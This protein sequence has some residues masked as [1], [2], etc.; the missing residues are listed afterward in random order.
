MRVLI[1]VGGVAVALVVGVFL[2]DRIMLW[3]EA[4]GWVYWRMTQP[5]RS[6]AGSA[7]LELQSMLEP[8]RKYVLEARR[9]EEES[10]EQR[11]AQGDG[12]RPPKI[13]DV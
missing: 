1:V 4:R 8:D 11:D 10:V 13:P 6:G 5:N 3:M 12:N 7:F 9:Q 2:F